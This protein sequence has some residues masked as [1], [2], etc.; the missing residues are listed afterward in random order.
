MKRWKPRG[1]QIG[2]YMGCL[3]RAACDRAMFHGILDVGPDQYATIEAAKQSSPYADLG[4]A[5]H[6]HLQAGLGAVF[7]KGVGPPGP[8]VLINAS[9]LFDHDMDKTSIAVRNSAIRAAADPIWTL[10]DG[11]KWLAEVSVNQKD[12]TGHIDFLASDHSI[13]VDLKTT[14]KPPN[15]GRAKQAHVAQVLCYAFALDPVPAKVSILYVD[16]LRANWS[17]RVDLDTTDPAMQE[18]AGQVL[19]FTKLVRGQALWKTAWPNIGPS[20]EEWCPYTSICRDKYR[21][22]PSD[23]PLSQPQPIKARNPFQ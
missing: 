1:S 23:S 9:S 2:H 7:P 5:I 3:Y 17:F 8:E 16:S 15:A 11:V 19:S 12:Y 13:L 22:K 18:Y 10:P 21:P 6:Y 20:C 4:T 14:S